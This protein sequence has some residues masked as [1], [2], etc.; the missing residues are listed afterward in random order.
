MVY[1]DVQDVIRDFLSLADLEVVTSYHGMFKKH[2]AVQFKFPGQEDLL[3]Y[4]CF[5]AGFNYVQAVKLLKC[6]GTAYSQLFG[7]SIHQPPL[8]VEV[9]PRRKKV[10]AGK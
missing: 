6:P 3:R 1:S 10:K 9:N 2:S 5:K 7:G 8:F 4:V